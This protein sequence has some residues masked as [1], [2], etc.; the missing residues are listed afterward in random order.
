MQTKCNNTIKLNTDRIILAQMKQRENS[1]T[2]FILAH[3][4][5]QEIN[6]ATGNANDKYACWMFHA[7]NNTLDT[8]QTQR[9]HHRFD[10]IIRANIAHEQQEERH[11]LI[12]EYKGI[13]KEKKAHNN[14]KF[15]L[16]SIISVIRNQSHFICSCYNHSNFTS[17]NKKK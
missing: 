11:E 8:N 14:H 15:I 5:F 12:H 17:I 16:I 3:Q 10:S 2:V 1:I 13:K 6:N 9:Q 4:K 7:L